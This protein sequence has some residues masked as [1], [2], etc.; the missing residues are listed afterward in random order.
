M[1]TQISI[2]AVWSVSAVCFIDL[3]LCLFQANGEDCTFSSLITV[4]IF[5]NCYKLKVPF[6]GQNN[7]PFVEEELFLY[8]IKTK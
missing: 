7:K 3:N 8:R 4:I 1:N 5:C 6:L 2:C